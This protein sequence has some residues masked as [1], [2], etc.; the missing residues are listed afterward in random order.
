M[1]RSEPKLLNASL[2]MK[3]APMIWL[4]LQAFI[5]LNLGSPNFL[6]RGPQKLLLTSSRATKA[7][8]HQFEGR[9]S[10]TM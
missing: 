3:A 1:H 6:V 7:I 4:R 10:Y 2:L 8:T 9:T 5:Y